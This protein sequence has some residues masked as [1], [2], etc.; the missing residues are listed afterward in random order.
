MSHSLQDEEGYEENAYDESETQDVGSW[1]NVQQDDKSETHDTDEHQQ[2]DGN[3]SLKAHER[4]KKRALRS[5]PKELGKGGSRK[6]YVESFW[7]S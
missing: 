1:F 3:G 5:K 2:D 7:T 6:T 4:T